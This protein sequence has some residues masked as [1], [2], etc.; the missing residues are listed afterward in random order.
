MHMT[1][2]QWD[3]CVPGALEWEGWART[4]KAI[5]NRSQRNS[6]LVAPCSR[7]VRSSVGIA[8]KSGQAERHVPA[9]SEGIGRVSW[10]WGGRT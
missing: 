1:V 3:D 6:T 4:L 8:V 7:K 2:K 9:D 10:S 5:R